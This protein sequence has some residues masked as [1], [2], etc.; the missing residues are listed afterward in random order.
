MSAADYDTI[1][2]NGNSSDAEKGQMDALKEI[3]TNRSVVMSAD[4]FEKLYLSPHNKVKG[5]LRQT[6]GNPTPLAL[7]GF[8]LCLSPLS[9]TLMGWRDAGGFAA[10]I[11]PGYF[12]FGGMLM[13]FSGLLEWV[14]GNSFPS[15]VF[16]SYGCFWFTFGGI[17]CPSF[18]AYEFYASSGEA[19][20]S[21]LLAPGFN[22]SLAF[23][24]V[25]FGLLCVVMFVCSLRTNV[26]FVLI[27]LTL[28]PAFGCL[29]AAFWYMAEDYTGTAAKQAKLMQAGGAILFVT[30]ACGWYILLSIMLAIVDFPIQLPV[31]DLST[32]IKGKS[33]RR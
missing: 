17:L 19:A 8:L 12:F 13:F 5:E 27:F 1:Q 18:G 10:S 11:I 4:M 24:L 33:E 15:I 2:R 6:Y 32:V 29:G 21:G 28:I 26:V 23:F 22:S 30:C 7:I 16:C 14:L 31:G 3:Q 20:A 25:S 9:C